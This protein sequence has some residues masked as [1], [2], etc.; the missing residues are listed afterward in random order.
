LDKKQNTI[1]KITRAMPPAQVEHLSSSPST[2]E[3]KKEK[4]KKYGSLPF[5]ISEPNPDI[6]RCCKRP[7]VFK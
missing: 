3:R 1:S 6:Q 7:R 2:V 5:W 4:E